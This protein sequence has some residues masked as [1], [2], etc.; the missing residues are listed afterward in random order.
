MR[1]LTPDRKAATQQTAPHTQSPNS[2][3]VWMV[4]DFPG[5]PVADS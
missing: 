5:H 4:R 2:S 1:L 3:R